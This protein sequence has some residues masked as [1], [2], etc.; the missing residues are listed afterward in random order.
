M[1]QTVTATSDPGTLDLLEILGWNGS[2]AIEEQL[3]RAY[4]DMLAAAFEST[5]R[6]HV[7]GSLLGELFGAL[8]ERNRT[9]FLTAP[10]TGW[11]LL[12]ENYDVK[13]LISSLFAEARLAGSQAALPAGTWTA[14]GD[15]YFP[16]GPATAGLPAQPGFEWREDQ[17]FRAP[18]LSNGI[19]IDVLS[20]HSKRRFANLDLPYAPLDPDDA[21]CLIP[22]IDGTMD[23]VGRCCGTAAAMITCFT[24][25]IVVVRSLSPKNEL[26]SFSTD[27]F[28]GRTT[29]VVPP[30]WRDEVTLA[31]A[32]V[33]EAIHAVLYI[34]ERTFP[35][36]TSGPGGVDRWQGIKDG[37]DEN[38]TI[39]ARSPWSG[40]ELTI[41]SFA[42]AVFVWFGLWQF[43][44]KALVQGTFRHDRALE[45][46]DNARR[47]FQG[48]ALSEV[49][50]LLEPRLCRRY[51]TAVG[52]M[53]DEIHRGTFE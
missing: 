3:W 40:R 53:L 16:N 13:F 39:T 20:P 1:T 51:L 47:G 48:G 7:A 23:K 25:T 41:Y 10:E 52:S 17:P 50:R 33:H 14:T 37:V 24:R 45:Q 28:V 21:R 15:W 5:Q 34:V 2:G 11:R 9:R 12:V 49:L 22:S 29:L 32:L 19:P 4:S 18:I 30:G 43:W 35:F 36:V 38:M 44:R 46:F 42:Q 26:R 31:N 27:R 8:P 6:L